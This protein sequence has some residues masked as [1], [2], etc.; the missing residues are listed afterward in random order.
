MKYY[1]ADYSKTFSFHSDGIPDRAV[2]TY[3]ILSAKQHIPL[4]HVEWCKAHCTYAW[5][6]WFDQD[7]S[8]MGFASQEESMWFSMANVD[9]YHAAWLS[10]HS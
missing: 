5:A 4:D 9:T 10:Y 1:P 6:W 2:C 7:K 3:V 8:Y